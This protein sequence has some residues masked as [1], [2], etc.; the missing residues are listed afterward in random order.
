MGNG[1][2]VSHTYLRGRDNNCEKKFSYG[3]GQ[4][5]ED[6]FEGGCRNSADHEKLRMLEQTLDR[7]LSQE[8]TK[9]HC[10][11]E[12]DGR[13]KVVRHPF[14]LEKMVDIDLLTGRVVPVHPNHP[15]L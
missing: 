5:F 10:R 8:L 3:R 14:L 15:K 13:V 9:Y 7:F 4:N 12:F 11:R 2:E 1:K 6:A